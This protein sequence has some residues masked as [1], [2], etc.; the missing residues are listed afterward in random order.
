MSHLSSTVYINQ[1]LNE[2]ERKLGIKTIK[3][4]TEELRKSGL[5]DIISDAS[6]AAAFIYQGDIYV[7]EDIAGTDSK[8]H[9][10]LHI[11]MGAM[12]FKIQNYMQIL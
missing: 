11:L 12:K 5:F 7:N 8:V 2:I 9:E 6:T 1:A 4:T 3:T 10:L